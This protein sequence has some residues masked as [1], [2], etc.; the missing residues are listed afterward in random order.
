MHIISHDVGSG[1]G[2][3]ANLISPVVHSGSTPD[4]FEAMPRPSA[5]APTTAYPSECPSRKLCVL[6]EVRFSEN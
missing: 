6:A 3:A 5:V 4:G 2:A 1:L